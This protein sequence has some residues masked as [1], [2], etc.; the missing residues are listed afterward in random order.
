MMLYSC[1]SEE[2]IISEVKMNDEISDSKIEWEGEYKKDIIVEDEKGINQVFY[3][4]YSNEEGFI[5]DFLDNN[6][7]TIKV[8]T[9]DY[10]RA[11]Q[12]ELEPYKPLKSNGNEYDLDASPL[13]TIELVSTNLKSDVTDYSLEVETKKLK[14]ANF[15][16]STWPVSYTTKND[17]IGIVHRGTGYEFV[18]KYRYKKNWIS[19]WR[20]VEV[21]GGVN[22]WFVTPYSSYYGSFSSG[23]YRKRAVVVYSHRDQN[24]VNYHIAYSNE[25]FRSRICE[26]GT[27]DY[28]GYGECYVGSSPEGTTA[29]VYGDDE[30]SLNFYYTP[31]N[32]DECP[33]EGS[34]FDGANCFVMDVPAGCEPY[35][36][37]RNWLVKSKKLYE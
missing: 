15:A 23:D 11:K 36:W 21:D 29:F 5:A 2:E 9:N 16:F 14:S 8:N 17:F 30:N 27:Y 26:I 3:T 22:A 1:S 25:D 10:S 24:G 7:L 28:N 18:T 37:R 34:S 33:M 12:S 20:E 6:T 13:L 35:T 32:G 4:L 31:I 19:S